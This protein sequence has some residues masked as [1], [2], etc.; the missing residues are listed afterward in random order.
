MSKKGL[1]PVVAMILLL[2]MTVAA[3]GSSFYWLV[4]IQSEL[5]GGTQAHQ[6]STFEA[7]T[8]SVI[9]QTSSYNR[10][11]EILQIVALNTGTTKIPISDSGNSPKSVWTLTNSDGDILCNSDWSGLDSDGDGTNDTKC[12]SGCGSDLVLK[13]SRTI[14]LNLTNS[15]CDISSQSNGS[16]VAVDITLSGVTPLKGQF[17]I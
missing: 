17:E 6:D 2:M 13:D 10:T 1:T 12:L 4:R 8:S 3:A 9:W 7:M 14:K 5:Q 11:S 16:T 15:E